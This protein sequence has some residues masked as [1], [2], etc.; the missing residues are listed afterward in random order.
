MYHSGS[1]ID[2]KNCDNMSFLEQRYRD[3]VQPEE[4]EISTHCPDHDATNNAT[5]HFHH[6]DEERESPPRK[7]KASASCLYDSDSSSQEL[8]WKEEGEEEE[9]EFD[10]L[11]NR[12]TKKN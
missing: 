7:R 10:V 6:N 9:E 12:N 8:E 11:V 4:R 1:Y 3:V 5:R 2:L